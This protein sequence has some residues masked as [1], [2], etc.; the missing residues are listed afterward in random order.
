MSDTDNEPSE[1]DF[2]AAQYGLPIEHLFMVDPL[3]LTTED[4]LLIVGHYR[5]ARLNHLKAMERPKSV[6][7]SRNPKLDADQTRKEVSAIM[8][9]ILDAE[10]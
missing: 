4:L 7:K 9:A 8:Q 1:D 10:D 2:H 3:D 5:A 6:A